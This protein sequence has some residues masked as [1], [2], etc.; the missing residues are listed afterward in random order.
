MRTK[1]RSTEMEQNRYGSPFK[2]CGYVY[3]I[4]VFLKFFLDKCVQKLNIWILVNVQKMN[5]TTW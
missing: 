1:C 5:D 3:N 2:K 4:A